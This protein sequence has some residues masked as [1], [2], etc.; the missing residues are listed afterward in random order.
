MRLRF[1]VDDR[2]EFDQRLRRSDQLCVGAAPDDVCD[3]AASHRHLSASPPDRKLS[4]R[5]ARL[6]AA[7]GGGW[8]VEIANLNQADVRNWGQPTYPVEQGGLV[9]VTDR[10]TAVWLRGTPQR[11]YLLLCEPEPT[12]VRRIARD[13]RVTESNEVDRLSEKETEAIRVV[14]EQHLRWPPLRNPDPRPKKSAADRL[15][16]KQT[17]LNDRLAGAL[18]KARRVGY[19]PPGGQVAPTRDADWVYW[20]VG[21]GALDFEMHAGIG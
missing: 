2:V 10:P 4:R 3:D 1:L 9:S 19:Q 11:S 13:R 21:I 6:S 8:N 16:I 14:F 7:P 15:G 18:E 20:L 5:A 17:S 12:G